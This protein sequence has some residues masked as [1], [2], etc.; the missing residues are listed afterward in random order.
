LLKLGALFWIADQ[1][2]SEGR[3]VAQE[4]LGQVYFRSMS[5]TKRLVRELRMS[6]S[7]LDIL[8]KYSGMATRHFV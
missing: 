2:E 7:E 4:D 8:A 1:N 5:A 3:L 6:V